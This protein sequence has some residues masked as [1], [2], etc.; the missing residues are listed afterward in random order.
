MTP[1]TTA[2]LDAGAPP[3]GR[4]NTI[5]AT[6]ALLSTVTTQPVIVE[7]GTA[8]SRLGMVSDGWATRVWGWYA[9][10]HGGQ[11]HSIDCDQL[12]ITNARRLCG[13]TVHFIQ[14]RAEQVI[15]KFPAIDLLYMD[16]PNDAAIHLA[17]W[18][19]LTCRPRL[20]LWDDIIGPGASVPGATPALLDAR[21]AALWQHLTRT[22]PLW[23]VKGE[24]AIPEMLRAGYDV[25]FHR[26][27]QALLQDTQ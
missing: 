26:D 23:A 1:I 16:G 7:V 24:L 15:G 3:S 8:R 19:A 20:V 10:Q 4:R 11:A 17:I 18:R 12:A 13:D 9:G 14:A 2:E 22:A 27:R 21:K 5:C 25:V 6:L